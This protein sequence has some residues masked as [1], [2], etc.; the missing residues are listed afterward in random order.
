MKSIAHLQ[1][2]LRAGR[3][4]LVL[5]L[6][7]SFQQDGQVR[8]WEVGLQELGLLFG[9]V[10]LVHLQQQQTVVRVERLRA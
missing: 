1:Q 3:V 10:R 7:G 8:A 4:F 2:L 6:D 9:L 5:V